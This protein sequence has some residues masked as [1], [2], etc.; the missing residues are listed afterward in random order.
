MSDK[1]HLFDKIASLK[2]LSCAKLVCAAGSR[3]A[4]HI[5]PLPTLAASAEA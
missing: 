2:V 1:R 5:L 3:R 4:T